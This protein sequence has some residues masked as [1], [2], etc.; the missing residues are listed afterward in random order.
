MRHICTDGAC[1]MRHICTDGVCHMRTEWLQQVQFLKNLNLA[2]LGHHFR[3]SVGLMLATTGLF[4]D[5]L[6]FFK[7]ILEKAVATD[8]CLIHLTDY[9]QNQVSYGNFTV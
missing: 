9:S 2:V 5:Y 3:K 6:C 7:N 1:H 4:V 8:T